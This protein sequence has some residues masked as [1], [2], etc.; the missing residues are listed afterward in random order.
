MNMNARNQYLKVL[1][2]RYFVA[3]SKKEKSTIL[4]EYCKNTGLYVKTCGE[5]LMG[6]N[7]NIIFFA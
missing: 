5:N 1:Q 2:E 4:D 6:T 7:P 3:K